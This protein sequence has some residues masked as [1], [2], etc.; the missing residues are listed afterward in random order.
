MN[1][2][3]GKILIIFGIIFIIIGLLISY[4]NIGKFLGKLPGDI[5][6]KK[7][8]VS[9]HFPIIACLLISIIITILLN[10]FLRK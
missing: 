8:N 2:M 5:H 6:Y 4:T 7:G 10:I 1:P 9:F 3:I